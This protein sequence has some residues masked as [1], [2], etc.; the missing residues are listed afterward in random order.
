MPARISANSPGLCFGPS[1][2]THVHVCA[3]ASVFAYGCQT[4][5]LGVLLT[6]CLAFF[7]KMVKI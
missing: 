4:L 7:S 1:V 5:L 6:Q 2:Y 3:H